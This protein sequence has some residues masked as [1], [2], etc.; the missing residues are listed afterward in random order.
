[1]VQYDIKHVLKILGEARK[2][3]YRLC[4]ERLILNL[5]LKAQEENSRKRSKHEF[6]RWI[7]QR[8][9]LILL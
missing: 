6:K 8:P 7:L 9:L 5:E 4:F 1:M 2:Y 3:L